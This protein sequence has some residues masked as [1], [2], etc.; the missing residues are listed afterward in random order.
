MLQCKASSSACALH[1]AAFYIRKDSA[2]TVI[3]SPESSHFISSLDYLT[4]H[5]HILINKNIFFKKHTETSPNFTTLSTYCPFLC[6]IWKENLAQKSFRDFF[7]HLISRSW[8][9]RR[10]GKPGK[11]E[12]GWQC[13]AQAH[14]LLIKSGLSGR[15]G[16][17]MNGCRMQQI[18]PATCCET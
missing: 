3:L 9:T 4:A 10:P 11:G 7:L 13:L 16:W 6:F 15:K 8:F 14:R 5:K 17:G 18:M 2:P 1:L 12:W